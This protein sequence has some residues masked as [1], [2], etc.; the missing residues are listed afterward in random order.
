MPYGCGIT[1]EAIVTASQSNR[2]EIRRFITIRTFGDYRT[3]TTPCR[4]KELLRRRHGH[5]RGRSLGVREHLVQFGAFQIP[6][7][8][9]DGGD[10]LCICD[11]LQRTCVEQNEVRSL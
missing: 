5:C 1:R 11:A 10:A 2:P 6:P 4:C 3:T 8:P 7:A 9:N